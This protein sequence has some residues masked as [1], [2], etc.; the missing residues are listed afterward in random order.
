MKAHFVE[1]DFNSLLFQYVPFHGADNI[2]HFYE[3]I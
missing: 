1:Y 3:V 2:F